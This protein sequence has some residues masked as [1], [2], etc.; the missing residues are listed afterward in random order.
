MAPWLSVV[1][2]LV[3]DTSSIPSAHITCNSSSKRSDPLFWSVFIYTHALTYRHTHTQ[4][5]NNKH[6]EVR[7]NLN[8]FSWLDAE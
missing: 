1:A 4:F 8:I 5:E 3:G 7:K 2:V 6:F